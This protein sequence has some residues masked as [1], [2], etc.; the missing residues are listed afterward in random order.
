MQIPSI[1]PTIKFDK[2]EFNKESL[3]LKDLNLKSS[4]LKNEFYKNKDRFSYWERK[5]LDLSKNNK[6]I[7]MKIQS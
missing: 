7:N 5:L 6:L 2:I 1:G 4:D 3:S